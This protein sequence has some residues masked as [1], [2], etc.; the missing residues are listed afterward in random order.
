MAKNTDKN[1]AKADFNSG[2]QAQSGAV[3]PSAPTAGTEQ[4]GNTSDERRALGQQ[5]PQSTRAGQM[6]GNPGDNQ[7]EASQRASAAATTNKRPDRS[8]SGDNQ[9]DESRRSGASV[10]SMN[11]SHGGSDRTFRCADVGNADCRWE[12]SGHTDDEIMRRAEEH[13]RREH[14]MSD[15]TEAMRGKVKDAIRYREAA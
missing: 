1:T 8:G 12:T 4:W 9:A 3:N 14:G 7:T 11:T 10:H 5:D 2:S 15:W 6:K 13:G